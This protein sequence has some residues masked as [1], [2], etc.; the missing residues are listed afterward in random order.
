MIGSFSCVSSKHDI[1]EGSNYRASHTTSC[2]LNTL[3]KI[4]LTLNWNNTNL[5]VNFLDGT[6]YFLEKKGEELWF[7]TQIVY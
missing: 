1:G 3:V 2:V 7:L 6:P 5:I 4:R